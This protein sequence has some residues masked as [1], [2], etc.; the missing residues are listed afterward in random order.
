MMYSTA[1]LKAKKQ[2]IKQNFLK[3]RRSVLSHHNYKTTGY[4]ELVERA[5]YS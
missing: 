5:R 1:Y 2:I 3:R 4:L